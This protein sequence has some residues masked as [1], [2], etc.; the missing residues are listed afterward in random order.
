MNA[1]K[2]AKTVGSTIDRMLRSGAMLKSPPP[3]FYPLLS[4][5]PPPSLVRF[6][7]A[8]PTTDLPA[9]TTIPDTPYRAA[10][11]KLDAG[12]R[13]T[14]DEKLLLE[15]PQPA[16]ITRRKPPRKANSAKSRPMPIVFQDDEIRRQF[17]RDHPF[18]AYR[19][20]FLAEGETVQAARGPQGVEWTEL[21]QRTIV[22]TAEE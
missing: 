15:A 19:P 21:R 2:S 14:D 8:R 4:H 17:F 16:S 10:R 1:R 3:A 20:V 11:A 5:P 9:T 18:E 13:L 22:P 7:P 12:I 6:N